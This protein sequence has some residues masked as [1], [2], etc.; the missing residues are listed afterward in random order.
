[1][2]VAY[3]VPDVLNIYFVGDANG[4]CGWAWFTYSQ[5]DYI[6][7]D[8]SCASNKSTL[9]HEIG[10]YFNLYHTH[11]TAFGAECVN[12]SNCTTA[13]DRLCDTPADPNLSG[14][15]SS[16]C[17]YTGTNTD[18][19]T[20]A[21]YTPSTHNLMSYSR[22]ACRDIFSAQQ[23]AKILYTIA[24]G[25]SYL[26]YGC[27][28]PN[29]LCAKAQVIPAADAT[30]C[31]TTV[32]ATANNPNGGAT[33][34]TYADAQGEGVWYKFTGDCNVWNFYFPA[35]SGWDPEV[36]VYSGTCASLTCVTGDDDSGAGLSAS[37]SVNTTTGT[38]YYVY[39]HDAIG[40]STSA[41]CFTLTI[42]PDNTPPSVTCKAHTAV[43]NGSGIASITMTDVYASG[44]DN[45][46]TV[47]LV[48]V[49]PNTF[50]CGNQG[51]N[52]VTLTVNDGNGNSN[53]CTATVTVVDNTPPTI[54]CKAHTAV[55]NGSGTA[56][57][58]MTDVYA[59][60]SDNCG[61]VNLVTV[62]PNTFNCSN[63]GGNTV[64]LTVNDGNGNSNTCTATVTVIDN[65]PPTVTCKPHTAVLD[66]SGSASIVPADVYQSSSD[67]C[68]TV[69]L[70]SV[71]PN[72]FNCGNQGGNTVTLTV[73]DGNG[74]TSTCTAT[75]TVVDNTPPSV[76]CKPHTAV[77]DGTGSASITM[78]DVYDSGSDNC[79][80]V[81]LVNVT[82]FSFNCSDLGANTVTLFVN[83][84]NGNFNN[85]TAT[86]TV[87][88]N[89]APTATCKPHTAQL[90]ASGSATISP[91]DVFDSGSD[92][93]GTV[94]P[95]SVT[96]NTFGCSNVGANTVTLTVNDGNGNTATCSA[97][98]T[99]QDNV[100]PAANCKNIT[101]V[102]SAGGTATIAEDAVNDGSSDAC[103]IV[104][105]DTD[106]TS[107]DCGDVGANTVTLTVTD[108]NGNS[109]TCTATVT[110]QDNTAPSAN[111]KNFTTALDPDGYYT[112]AP[113][114]VDDGSSDACGVTLSV[115]PNSFD[116]GDEGTN[117]VTLTVT[118]DNGNS[119]TC[120]ATI[121][122]TEFVAIVSIVVTDETCAG[123]ADGT[124]TITAT[125]V[126][127][128]LVYSITG[129]SSYQ[130][131]N[132]FNDVSPGVY[133]ISV[134]AQGTSSC[135]ATSSATVNAGPTA[136]T[137]YKD[138]DGD[139]YTDGV[140]QV[141]CSQPTCFVATATTGDC[142]DNDGTIHP[143]ASE[144]CDGLDNDCDGNVPANEADADADGYRICD[145]DCDDTN[146][147]VNPGATEVCNGIDDDCD[148]DVDE[149]VSGGLT[150]VGNVTFVTQA[151]VDA[152]S[153]CYDKIQGHLTIQG[154]TINSLANLINLT[155]V[156]GNVTIK[157]TGL[158]NMGG[159]DNLTT[160]GGTLTIQF[161]N[162]GAHLTS[163][164]GLGA[165]TSVGANL[166]ITTNVYLS[167]CCSIDALLDN[168]GVGGST[169]IYGNAFGCQSVA[170]INTACGGSII[171]PPNT[172]VS[173]S[174]QIDSYRMTVF[175]NPASGEVT[176]HLGGMNNSE[177]TLT[178]YDQLGRVVLVERLA[179]GQN[180]LTLSLDEGQF[181][182]GI[183][184][185]SVMVQGE[186]LTKRLVVAR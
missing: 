148:G 127:G 125:A 165:V 105:Y 46:G 39:V 45:C 128:T 33:C 40:S 179:E 107:F 121:T 17:N 130:T 183:Y 172:G 27:A 76:T 153:Q 64:T 102:L 159:L 143:G 126:G 151:Q 140:T 19:C 28:P 147:A 84:G 52:T 65:T 99:V 66:G 155:E 157:F 177:P 166:I 91:A 175:P 80:T 185:V 118:D 79:G 109:S 137:W 37:F 77:L 50:N 48:S 156:T 120:T 59:S 169:I 89:M 1:M 12:G 70:V 117:T 47:N 145:G 97:T 73:N 176:I 114:S 186:R 86:V 29:D 68:G 49:S 182:N 181:R 26:N 88:D 41:F 146:A 124:I 103:G 161:N 3:N 56:S 21:S 35:A 174:E 8:N 78:T 15:V 162:Y 131:T 98:V 14:K 110:V 61:T 152:F 115:S 5:Y 132:V 184:M 123:A 100:A 90:D 36:N 112:L 108:N 7:I 53:T 38:T 58:T 67:N 30:I 158:P 96:P 82:P 63:Q 139:G 144:L 180:T 60:G 75:V 81:N 129:G 138:L 23:N 22:K 116:C 93:C 167:D 24:H 154:M 134:L 54:T 113:A 62:S 16:A 122:I 168:A 4:Y 18:G 95:A 104:S 101:V 42:T 51:G 171:A 44:S 142:N 178:I 69:N 164:N 2:S 57:I 9:A 141:S 106:V 136:T 43:L 133:D 160:I 71:S 94:T 111:C 163:L 6:V 25:R 83:D 87:V 173:S 149:G 92:N 72:T 74:N 119:S 135:T 85:C 34:G 11:E 13:G 31:G 10:H 55:L 170:Q 20:G 32:N 150:Y